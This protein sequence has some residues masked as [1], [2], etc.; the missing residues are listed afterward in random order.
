MMFGQDRE[1]MRRFFAE[2]WRKSS[3]ATPLEPMEQLVAGVIGQHPEYH[4]MLAGDRLD[5]EYPPELG[6]ANPFLHMG[7]HIAL[8][9]QVAAG[10][11]GDIAALYAGIAARLGDGHEA[12]HRMMECLGEALWRAQ[13]DGA[14]PDED[15]Y[16]ECL[17][18]LAHG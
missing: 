16:L 6:A 2:V 10:R 5:L 8:Q 13:R 9:E 1:Q 14:V 17:R 7:M 12:E 11:P 3:A 18:R 15:A 4:G